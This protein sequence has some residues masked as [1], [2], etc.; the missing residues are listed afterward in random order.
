M[1]STTLALLGIATGGALLAVVRSRASSSPHAP[2]PTPTPNVPP[3]CVWDATLGRPLC[4]GALIPGQ[5]SNADGRRVLLDLR[6]QAFPGVSPGA[7]AFVPAGFDPRAPFDL[8]LY[9]RGHN[10]CVEVV[11]GT[12][13]GACRASNIVGQF[14]DA[15]RGRNALLLLPEL[16]REQATG[17]P[18][19]LARAG[20]AQALVDEALAVLGVTARPARVVALAH[21]G[22]Y[23]ALAHAARVAGLTGVGL[24]DALY[25]SEGSFRAFAADPT[26][27]LVNVYG[28]STATQSERLAAA[29][30]GAVLRR[31]PGR[32]APGP[33][34]AFQRSGLAHD[35]VARQEF[36]PVLRALLP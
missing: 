7:L 31:T 17:D 4:P 19:Q 30:P 27:R 33:R 26:H 18:G 24:L 29:I 13:P 16:R 23:V 12:A 9:F 15:T 22:G 11:A 28:S 14:L 6:A 10:N 8:V 35:E 36:G 34:V 32:F 1:K 5:V 3:G 20:G 2:T 21:S 25:G